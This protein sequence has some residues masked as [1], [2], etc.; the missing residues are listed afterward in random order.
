MTQRT[1]ACDQACTTGNGLIDP[2]ANSLNFAFGDQWADV[3]M[4]ASW[5]TD[6]Q[7][8]TYMA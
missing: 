3:G 7:S 2:L 4:D 6:H 1:T 8:I 5:I